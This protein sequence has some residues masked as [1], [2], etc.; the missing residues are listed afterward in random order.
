MSE[1]PDF[2]MPVHPV[3]DLFPMMD[4][5]SLARLAVDITANGLLN[6]IVVHDGQIVDGRNRLIAC[7]SV[8]V[9][10]RFVQWREVYPGTMPVERWIWSLNVERRH[11]TTD[12]IAWAIVQRRAWE[13]KEAARARQLQ[14]G[15]R[16]KEGG[17][18]HE[19][20][21]PVV[22]PEGFSEPKGETRDL[23]AKE[24]GIS[25]NKVRQALAVQKLA[26]TGGITPAVAG[27]LRQ[28][29]VKL[30]EVLKQTQP[31]P[32]SMPVRKPSA[33]SE[34]PAPASATTSDA[35]ISKR[36]RI[37]STAAKTRMINVLSQIRGFCANLATVNVKSIAAASTAPE[38]DEWAGIAAEAAKELRLFSSKLAAQV[39]EKT[40]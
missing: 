21:L 39:K 4:A 36:Q 13:E 29:T 37:T 35:S 24:A 31:A 25:A 16:G 15:E 19:K 17:R 20:T 23:L 10:P 2:R 9:E 11:L 12:Q 6:P 32:A 3:C 7:R 33:P 18:G 30:H 5:T 27:H 22:P 14:A 34:P 38:L 26:E 28:G 40:A 8:G 1:R